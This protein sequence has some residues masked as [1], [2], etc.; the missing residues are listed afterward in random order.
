MAAR[1]HTVPPVG[2]E[3][4]PVIAPNWEMPDIEDA[5][6]QNFDL[7]LFAPRGYS[8]AAPSTRTRTRTAP[9]AAASGSGSDKD[10][11][12]DDGDEDDSPEENEFF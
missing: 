6:F 2:P 1:N 4:E 12:E 7:S 11:D 5:M 9:A 8:R 3:I 10:D